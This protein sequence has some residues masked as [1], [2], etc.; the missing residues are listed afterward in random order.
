[1]IKSL[2][3][4]SANLNGI[5]MTGV[6]TILTL[7]TFFHAFTQKSAY[8]TQSVRARGNQLSLMGAEMHRGAPHKE[9]RP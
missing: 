9:D 7:T 3:Q 2:S 1:M 6:S 8:N 4:A 5:E